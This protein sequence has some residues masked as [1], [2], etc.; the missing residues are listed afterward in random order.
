MVVLRRS[1][2]A[3]SLTLASL[4]LPL[5][6]AASSGTPTCRQSQLEVAVSWPLGG[7][8]AGTRYVTVLIVNQSTS[9][10]LLR[11]YPTIKVDVASPLV[12]HSVV[13]LRSTSTAVTNV[14]LAHQ[15]DASF[16]MAYGDAYDQGIAGPARYESTSGWV[17]L[18]NVAPAASAWFP[19]PTGFNLAYAGFR[20]RV[21]PIVAGPTPPR[22]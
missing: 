15:R 3:A 22:L 20:L 7:A 9:S 16:A 21:S 4:A 18:G 17:H 2:A 12:R 19:I 6:A 11:G 13:M 1:V 8:A 10:C 5:T 14:I